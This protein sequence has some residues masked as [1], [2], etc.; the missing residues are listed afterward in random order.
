MDV[1]DIPEPMVPNDRVN[2]RKNKAENTLE[3]LKKKFR[4]ILLAKKRGDENITN[5]EI[6]PENEER[7]CI[8]NASSTVTILEAERKTK[9]LE[10]VAKLIFPQVLYALV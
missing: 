2:K 3:K 8:L 6:L 7:M 5:I 4:T 9:D 10:Q 1:E